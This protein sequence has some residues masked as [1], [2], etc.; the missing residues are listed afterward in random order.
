VLEH[1]RYH[2]GEDVTHTDLRSGEDYA[3]LPTGLAEQRLHSLW[4]N[5]HT[6]FRGRTCRQ[7]SVGF[8][9]TAAEALRDLAAQMEFENHH[10]PGID[11]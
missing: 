8:G 3:G 9:D 7:V 10:L 11:F 6:L 2:S 4:R 5:L 1:A